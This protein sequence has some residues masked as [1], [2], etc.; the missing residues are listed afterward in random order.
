[1]VYQEVCRHLQL[2]EDAFADA[3]LRAGPFR[4]VQLQVRED[5]ELLWD[6]ERVACLVHAMDGST[7]ISPDEPLG[8]RLIARWPQLHTGPDT[9]ADRWWIPSHM[10]TIT[11]RSL[12]IQCCPV[13]QSWFIGH[14]RTGFCSGDCRQQHRRQQNTATVQRLRQR[15][16]DSI[17][18]DCAHCSAEFTPKRSTARFCSTACRVAAHRARS[19]DSAA[20]LEISFPPVGGSL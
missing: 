7:R 12:R 10:R 5:R 9:D 17:W 18:Q 11:I 14:R 1:M 4:P 6:G 13:C 3:V 20:L 16:R 19:A 2:E 8:Q 15:R